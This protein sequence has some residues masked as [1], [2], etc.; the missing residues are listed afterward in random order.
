M[1]YKIKQPEIPQ[2]TI[3]NFPIYLGIDPGVNGAIA[4]YRV[5]SNKLKIEDMPTF[6]QKG[7]GLMAESGFPLKEI[8]LDRYF[9]L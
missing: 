3:N 6:K 8:S 9:F 1:V 7:E 4:F 2:K 5:G